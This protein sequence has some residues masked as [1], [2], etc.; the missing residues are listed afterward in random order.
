MANIRLQVALLPTLI[1]EDLIERS[2]RCPLAIVIDT[3][4]FTTTAATALAAGAAGVRV[5]S[6]PTEAQRIASGMPQPPLLGGER[7]CHKIPGFDLGNSPLEYSAEAVA[8][9]ELVFSTTNGTRAVVAAAKIAERILLGALVNRQAVVEEIMRSRPSE[10]WIVC[11]GTNHQIA[12]EDTLTAGALL[13]AMLDISSLECEL[14]NDA[15]TIAFHAWRSLT[16]ERPDAPSTG[17][18]EDQLK[19]A[20]GGKNLLPKYA[21]DIAFAARLDRLAIAP[22]STTTAELRFT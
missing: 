11:S 17:V 7:L 2:S 3:L 8:G 22:A 13:A 20:Q 12:T 16:S 14:G 4:R 18:L 6:D 9:R 15:A 10:L 21:Q 19:N 1:G 5:S